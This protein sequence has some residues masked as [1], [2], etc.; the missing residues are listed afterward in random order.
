MSVCCVKLMLLDEEL[1]TFEKD[2]IYLYL[3]GAH[4][5]AR[6]GE[7]P[8]PQYQKGADSTVAGLRIQ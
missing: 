4:Y 7:L 3:E 1:E 2:M 8:S 5:R 6:L